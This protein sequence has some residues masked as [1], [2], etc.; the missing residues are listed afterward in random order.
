MKRRR[1]IASLGGTMVAA[2]G[3]ARAQQTGKIRRV[4]FLSGRA[5]PDSFE[6]DAHGAFL[7]GMQAAS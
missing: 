2:F 3:A 4:G 7:S 1:F 5:R 6:K